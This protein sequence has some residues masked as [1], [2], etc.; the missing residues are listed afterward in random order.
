MLANDNVAYEHSAV[1][2]APTHFVELSVYAATRRT[3]RQ[4]YPLEPC[5][6]LRCRHIRAV[7]AAHDWCDRDEDTRSQCGGDFAMR[8]HHLNAKLFD[9]YRDGPVAANDATDALAFVTV[10]DDVVQDHPRVVYVFRHVTNG[11]R[12]EQ[13]EFLRDDLVRRFG[14][15][16]LAAY[17]QPATLARLF[18]RRRPRAPQRH[19]RPTSMPATPPPPS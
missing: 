5:Q 2:F 16:P 8:K 1:P 10:F 11:T 3:S 13:R 7:Q 6:P 14:E 17:L 19:A 4:I 12:M 15:Q 9:N 18:A